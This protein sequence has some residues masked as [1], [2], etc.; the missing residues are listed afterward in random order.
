MWSFNGKKSERS[1]KMQ[2]VKAFKTMLRCQAIL[3]LILI[4]GSWGNV[5]YGA[6]AVD[7][8][9]ELIDKLIKKVDDLVNKVDMLENKLNA[10]AAIPAVAPVSDEVLQKKVSEMMMHEKEKGGLL[11]EII[12]GPKISGY[13]DT[14]YN[15]NFNKPAS[16]TTTVGTPNGAAGVNLSSYVTRAN[17]FDLTAAHVSLSGSL[18]NAGYVVEFDAGTT[19]NVDTPLTGAGG[20]D[21]FDLQE[22]YLTYAC[23]ITG[24]NLK[25]GKF[26]TL[27]GIEVIES[28]SNPTISRGL[29]YAMA[30]P[31]TNVGFLLSRAVPIK[32]LEGLE[33]RAGVVNGWDQLTDNNDGKTVIGGLGINYGDLATGGLSIYYGPEQANND[34]NHRTSVDLTIFN[35]SIENLTLGLQANWGREDGISNETDSWYGFGVQPIYRFTEKFCLAGRV[36]YMENKRGSRF[37]NDGGNITNF[38]ITPTFNITKN[39]TFRTEYRYDIASDDFFESDSGVFEKDHAS[40]VLG[41]FIYNF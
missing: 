18:K 12:S 14:T 2:I 23:P 16:Q 24:I 27:E 21:D 4:M 10:Q 25:A 13:V 7:P 41:E 30:E 1:T 8:K 5:S 9:D 28:P 32:G 11:G 34:S 6:D 26:V 38:T 15:Y 33:L 29:L 17:S 22:A 3:F 37:G 36:E 35:N 39:A 20:A 40:Q 19:A 31:F